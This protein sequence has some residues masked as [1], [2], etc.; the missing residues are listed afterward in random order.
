MYH[1]S[2][3]L[4]DD[5][6][7]AIKRV[8]EALQNEKFG[9]LNEINVDAVFKKKLDVDM[10]HY[11]ILGACS[12]TYAHRLVTEDADIGALLPCNILVR[13]EADKTTTVVFLDPVAVFGLSPNPK[14]TQIAEEAKAPLMRVRDVLE[15]G[16]G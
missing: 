10:P 2:V 11:R 9:I 1:F 4:T 12:P 3:K 8:T 6:E 7:T 16:N 14:V 15:A 5:F 13:E